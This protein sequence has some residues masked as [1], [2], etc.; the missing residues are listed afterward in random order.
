MLSDKNLDLKKILIITR[1][2]YPMQ[3]PRANRAAELA[4]EFSRQGY[5]VTVVHP[6]KIGIEPIPGFL[7][8]TYLSFG[9]LNWKTLIPYKEGGGTLRRMLNKLLITAPGFLLQYPSIEIF[10]KLRS[11]LKGL[12][13]RY[14]ILISIAN[15]HEI[16]WAIGQVWS[17]KRSNNFAKLWVADCGDPF[18]G[19]ENNRFG[20]R[21]PFYFGY[22]EKYWSRK[23]DYITIPIET[24][25]KGYYNE[26]HNKIR[27]IPQG[28]K[29]TDFKNDKHKLTNSVISFCYAGL[30]YKGNRDP[31]EFIEFLLTLKTEF[32]FYIFTKSTNLVDHYCSISNGRIIVSD[33]IPRVELLT[34]LSQMDFLVNFEN[35]GDA[36]K[37][38]KL[39]D[40][41]IV[42]KP[43]LSVKYKQLNIDYINEFI[44]GNYRNRMDLGNPTDYQIENI[45]ETFI[46]LYREKFK[47]QN[48]LN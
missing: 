29:F 18:M 4:K 1:A 13:N 44:S 46:S 34:F 43:V 7:N 31:S 32:R 12:E 42:D 2:F 35:S 17:N 40:Y 15:P 33:Y 47:P 8:I 26:F 30:F 21:T 25:K 41:L 45:V 6:G 16:H 38:S 10:F 3:T 11:F 27:I 36:Q 24:G 23:A 5:E 37:P 28:F 19:Q 39:I 14:D 9:N 20:L 48:L 22:I